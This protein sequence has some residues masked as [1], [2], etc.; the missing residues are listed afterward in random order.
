MTKL[1]VR[2]HAARKVGLGLFTGFWAG[3]AML[4]VAGFAAGLSAQVPLTQTHTSLAVETHEVAGHTMAAFR[5]AVQGEDGQPATGTVSLLDFQHGRVQDLAS[6]AL[7][8]EGKASLQLDSLTEGDHSIRAVFSG[9]PLHAGSRSQALFVHPQASAVPDFTLAIAPTSLSI[10]APG[11]SSTVN[12]TVTPTNSFTGFLSLSCSGPPTATTLPQGVT[13]TFA[14]A[15]L[16]LSA[17][18]TANPTGAVTANM[19]L[20]TSAPQLIANTQKPQTL[21]PGPRPVFLAGL[22]PGVLLLGF[23]G[24]K[25]KMLGRIVLVLLIG[26]VGMIGTTSCAARYY[27]LHHGPK[28]GGTPAGNYTIVV[29]AQ[30]SNGVTAASHF[31]SLAL[32]IK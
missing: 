15:N 31:A 5:A 25:R 1:T 28:F 8:A 4:T 6:A 24:R 32:T 26:A 3:I 20:V 16:Q 12:L 2:C 10:A 9:D 21:Q 7:D 11:D 23:L 18:T 19:T 22:I 17:P 14:P 13:C 27:Y 29:S 30:T